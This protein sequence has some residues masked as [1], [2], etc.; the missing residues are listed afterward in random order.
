MT[1]YQIAAYEKG[2][3]VIVVDQSDAYLLEEFD[4]TVFTCVWASPCP[5][6]KASPCLIEFGKC[7]FVDIPSHEKVI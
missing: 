5:R 1:Q 2:E 4:I 7:G 6:D 3:Y